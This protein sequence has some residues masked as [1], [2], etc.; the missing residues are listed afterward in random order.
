ML[1][2]GYN[3]PTAEISN[4]FYA[5]TEIS[6]ILTLTLW[7]CEFHTSI[8]SENVTLPNLS[9]DNHLSVSMSESRSSA[10]ASGSDISRTARKAICE[11]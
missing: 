1:R 2:Q 8:T 10:H 6:D 3:F 7:I 4:P 9:I 11:I 5:A